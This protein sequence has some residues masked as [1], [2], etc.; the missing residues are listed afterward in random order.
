MSSRFSIRVKHGS[1]FGNQLELAFVNFLNLFILCLCLLS[2]AGGAAE[3]QSNTCSHPNLVE[4]PTKNPVWKLCWVDPRN[5]SGLNASGLEIRNVRYKNQL[6]LNRGHIPV[7]SVKYKRG[8]CGGEYFTYRDWLG[9]PQFFQA[10]NVLLPGYAEPPASPV[11]VCELPGH[12][13]GDFKGVAVEKLADRLVLTSQLK[14]AWYRYIIKWIFY[15]DGTIEPR[16]GFSAV[17]Y[18]CTTNP[19]THHAFW[20]FDVDMGDAENDLVEE[21]NDGQWT[22]LGESAKLRNPATNRIWR[23]RDTRTNATLKLTPGASEVAADNFA[24]A[25]L[26]ALAFHEDELDDGGAIRGRFGDQPQMSKYLNGEPISDGKGNVV[27]WYHSGTFHNGDANKC[28]TVGPTLKV[29][30][31]K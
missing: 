2:A 12:D 13:T 14:S 1:K 4:W 8:G 29:S 6:I 25:D 28:D 11:T 16:I 31:K 3:A 27:L 23:V 5:S 7:L 18:F 19:H 30:L 17:D 24:V 9:D 20:R 10:N 15:A 26:W 21:S 22:P